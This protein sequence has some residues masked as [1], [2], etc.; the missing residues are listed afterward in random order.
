MSYVVDSNGGAYYVCTCIVTYCPGIYGPCIE[1]GP[2]R[3]I[4]GHTCIVLA[5]CDMQEYNS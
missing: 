1:D 5:L 4:P 3:I 2:A